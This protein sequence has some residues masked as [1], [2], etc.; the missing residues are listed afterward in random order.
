MTSYKP[1]QSTRRGL[2]FFFLKDEFQLGVNEFSKSNA[3]LMALVAKDF[4][5][6]LVS[7]F[8]KPVVM[9]LTYLQFVLFSFQLKLTNGSSSKLMSIIPSFTE[10][11]LRRSSFF[12]LLVLSSVSQLVMS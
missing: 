11:L 6:N 8:L 10:I 1:Y 9:L 12:N 7:I 5:K 3:T 4:H 2:L